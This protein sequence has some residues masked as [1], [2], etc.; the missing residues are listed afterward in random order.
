M[1]SARDG[2]VNKELAYMDL[3][4]LVGSYNEHDIYEKIDG[5]SSVSAVKALQVAAASGIRAPGST[6]I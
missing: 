6:R 1:V 4:G 5:F 2:D 3:H